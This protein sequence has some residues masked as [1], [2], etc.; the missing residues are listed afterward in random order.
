M[1]R[2]TFFVGMDL[3]S[4]KTSVAASNGRRETI[5]TTWGWPKDHVARAMLGCDVV[6]GE[7]VLQRRLALDVVRPFAKGALKYLNDSQA[8]VAPDEVQRRQ[9]AA[10][11]LVEHVISLLS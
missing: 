3:G 2:E 1:D 8:A 7:Q 11:L 10:R 6:F 5:Q 9:Q 4:F